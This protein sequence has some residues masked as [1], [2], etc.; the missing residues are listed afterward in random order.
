MVEGDETGIAHP[1]AVAHIDE[2][3]QPVVG[4]TR[5]L[6]PG[7]SIL[8][9]SHRKAQFVFASAGVMTV[10]TDRGAF[11]VPPQYAVWMPAGIVHRIN[12]RGHLAMRTLYVRDDAVPGLPEEVCVLRVSRLLRELVLAAVDIGPVY[13][14]DGPEFRMMQVIL[15]QLR[16]QPKVPLAL[17]M[18]IDRRLRKVAEA[19]VEDPSDNRG[20]EEWADVAGASPRTLARL[21]RSETGLSF[22]AWRQQ[23]R[24]Q[25]AVEMLSEGIPVTSVALD[26][27]YESPSAFTA[28]FRRTLGR[29]PTRYL[30][31][32]PPSGRP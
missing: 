19:L 32:A 31:S 11:V 9:H 4:Y 14:S 27:G 25:R 24:L 29:S 2:L 8:P 21:F 15:D 28:M 7:D 10:T 3:P 16:S 30:L 26:L 6:K 18:P 23:L 12:T 22:R 1:S 17:A 13:P 20:I 5:D